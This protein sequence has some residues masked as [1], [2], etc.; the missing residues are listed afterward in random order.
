[1]AGTVSAQAAAVT[2]LAAGTPVVAG[3]HDVDAA[4]LGIGAVT[5][6]AAS[7]ML[8]T[9][10][11]NQVVTD[12][13]DVDPRWQARAWLEPGRWLAMSTSPAGAVNF[14]WAMRRLGPLGPDG[15]PDPVAAVAEVVRSGLDARD[16][17]LP[18]FL[19]F[20]FGAP[21]G[22][23]APGAAWIGVHGWHE[24]GQLLHA[25]LE[26]VAFNHRTH[27]DGL[28]E[29]FAFSGAVRASGGGARSPEWTLLLADVLDRPVEVTDA[30][31]AG[32][33]GAAVLAGIGIGAYAGLDDAVART[34][35]VVRAQEPRPEQVAYR[36]GRYDRYLTAATGAP[37]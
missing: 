28:R 25:V 2:G 18:L 35:R 14:D 15:E 17:D 34:V 12:R 21:R 33:A 19:P 29:A 3:A 7:L 22:T 1:V 37:A 27:L 16:R 32:T 13:P 5:P 8:G 26:G 24:R 31:E 6:G 30:T 36:A 9:F 10:S 20:L 4:A 23:T 11:I